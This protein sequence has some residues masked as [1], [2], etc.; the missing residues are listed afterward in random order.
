MK[1]TCP[2][3]CSFLLER[4]AVLGLK[5][6]AMHEGRQRNKIKKKKKKKETRQKEPGPLPPW[7]VSPSSGLLSCV[8]E[9]TFTATEFFCHMQLTIIIIPYTKIFSKYVRN[10]MVIVE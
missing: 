5:V 4:V 6:E 8:K 2:P 7:D 10:E 3:S 9:L 1:E